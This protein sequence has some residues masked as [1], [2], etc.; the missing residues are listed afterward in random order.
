LESKLFICQKIS[1][2]NIEQANVE[3]I[4]QDMK[5]WIETGYIPERSYK[6]TS[7]TNAR[8]PIKWIIESFNEESLVKYDQC[9]YFELMK[10]IVAMEVCSNSPII[11]QR[12]TKMSKNTFAARVFLENNHSWIMLESDWEKKSGHPVEQT[13][14]Q[15]GGN[16]WCIVNHATPYYAKN[17]EQ[18]FEDD[19]IC[20]DNMLWVFGKN[21]QTGTYEFVNRMKKGYFETKLSDTEL[22]IVQKHL[23]ENINKS[24][25]IGNRF[26]H[27][28]LYLVLKGD[29]K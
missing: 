4:E 26:E 3:T 23:M 6:F 18:I 13:Y 14:K 1:G 28:A 9:K 16:G 7:M 17:N 8:N 12:R 19:I 20:L 25:L 27:Y 11:N 10:D 2:T 21:E 22:D 15:L 5:N 29:L 24:I